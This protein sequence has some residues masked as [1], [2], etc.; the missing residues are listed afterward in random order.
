MESRAA[1]LPGGSTAACREQGEARGFM[2]SEVQAW[3]AMTW[4]GEVEA[5]WDDGMGGQWDSDQP[6]K[7]TWLQIDE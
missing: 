5:W 4:E 2:D 6:I 3:W 1:R 7:T